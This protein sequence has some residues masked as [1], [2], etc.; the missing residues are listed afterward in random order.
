V[1]EKTVTNQLRWQ[2]EDLKAD[3]TMLEYR[4]GMNLRYHY[5]NY[6]KNDVH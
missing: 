6:F 1:P 5:Y 4:N 3:D 2:K